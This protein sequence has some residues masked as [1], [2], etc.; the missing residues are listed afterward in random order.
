VRSYRPE[1]GGLEARNALPFVLCARR[2][3]RISAFRSPDVIGAGKVLVSTEGMS[4]HPC[5]ADVWNDRLLVPYYDGTRL[6]FAGNVR[7]RFTPHLRR[8]VFAHLEPLH[9]AKCPFVDLP[10]SK[11]SDWAA[12]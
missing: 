12:A 5:R 11:T 6:R 7:A 2:R 4:D 9:T 10:N 1:H 3:E 8:Q